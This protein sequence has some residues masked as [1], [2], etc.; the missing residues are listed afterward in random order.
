MEK[1]SSET[2]EILRLEK[3]IPLYGVDFTEK[4]NPV[5]AG[6]ENAYSLTK[7]CYAGQEVVSKAIRVG[8]VPK[9]LSRMKLE[10]RIVPERG[11]AVTSREGKEIGKITSAVMSPLLGC[12]IAFGFLKRGF[13]TPGQVHWAGGLKAEVVERF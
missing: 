1:L 9:A 5:E 12:P 11:T 4:N 10:G 13:W 7:G 6:L 3:G 8:S 2:C